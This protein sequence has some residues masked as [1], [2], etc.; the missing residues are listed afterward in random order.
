MCHPR[1]GLPVGAAVWQGGT[2]AACGAI[3]SD[4]RLAVRTGW[5]GG[6]ELSNGPASDSLSPA[7]STLQL[8]D[9]KKLNIKS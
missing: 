3:Q 6:R 9:F 7:T 1:P 4:A 5:W 8:Q 2:V